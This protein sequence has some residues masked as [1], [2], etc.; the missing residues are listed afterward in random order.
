[1]V[2]CP[3]CSSEN[4][5]G[6]RFCS[7][8]GIS[9]EVGRSHEERKVI[10]ALFCDLVGSTA[11]GEQLDSEDVSRLLSAYRSICRRRIES[12][13]GVVEK[14]IGDA[15]VGVFGVPIAHEDDPERAVRAALKIV[16]D[17]NASDLDVEVRIGVNTGEA[18]VRLDVDPRL[19]EGFATGDALNT[20][21]RLESAAPTM[22]V[23]V[24]MQT[25]AASKTT[26]AYLDMPD[27]VAKGKA[28]PVSAWQALRPSPMQ[29]QKVRDESPFVGRELELTF[30][31]QLLDRSRSAPAT[32]FCTIIA[33]PGLGKSRL[34]RELAKH[35]DRLP[36][37]VT[38]RQGRCLPYGEGISF[39]ALGEIVKAEAGILESDD[40][41]TVSS[42]LDR[43]I[44]E[45]DPQTRSWVK[46]RL[47]P[48]VGWETAGG[49]PQRQEVFAAWRRFLEQ[50]A[51]SGPMVLVVEDLHWADPAFVAFLEEL[52]LRTVGLPLLVIVTAR[53]EVEEHHPSW[54]PGRHSTV[55]S[56]PP[57]SDNELQVLITETLPRPQS[58]LGRVILDRAGGSPLYAE[59][60]S[61][62]FRDRQA[63][64]DDEPLDETIIPSS[65]QALIAARI[66][67]LPP[68][69]KRA[70][71]NA[72]VVGRTFWAGAV[73][74]FDADA[75]L[76]ASFAELVRRD[77]CR[78]V[79]PS[80]MEGDQEFVFWHGLVRDVAYAELTRSE[81]S[82]MHAA[83]ALWLGRRTGNAMSE[84][85]EIVVHHID[86]AF[87]LAP[88]AAELDTDALQNLL[89]E[90]LIS[91]AQA[92]MRTEVPK[93]IEHL[94]RV[95]VIVPQGDPRRWDAL[96][97]LGHALHASGDLTRA[98]AILEELV[99][100]QQADG[101]DDAAAD[102]AIQLSGTMWMMGEG[103]QGDALVARVKERLGP[104]PTPALAKLLAYESMNLSLDH[105]DVPAI[106]LASKSLAMAANLRV[107]PPPR[108]LGARGMSRVSMGDLEGE[109]DIRQACDGFLQDLNPG[110]ASTMLFNL[111][112][113]MSVRGPR[114]ALPYYEE[115][116]EL[117]ERFGLEGEVWVGRAGRLES[118]AKMGRFDDVEREASPI[119]DWA[120]GHNDAFT[121][122]TV[123]SSLAVLDITRGGGCVD[124]SE[125]ADLARRMDNYD[126]LVRAAWLGL[127]AGATDMASGILDEVST[128]VLLMSAL[129][130]SRVAV[131][132]GRPEVAQSSLDRTTPYY[133]AQHAALFC[134]K[135][136]LAEADVDYLT[137]SNHYTE[138]VRILEEL[139]A[140]PDQAYSL[141]GLGRCLVGLGEAE[142]GVAYLTRSR[143]LWK[144][145]KATPRIA[146]IDSVLSAM[147]A[148]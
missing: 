135:A 71:M 136:I 2:V 83:T 92:S 27:V 30:L 118:L 139:G 112:D 89:A 66:D 62:M 64:T 94:E 43:A 7:S 23:V 82:R 15:V 12:H 86:A 130:L 74:E 53:P 132:L 93:A 96:R 21:A 32:E 81:R 31:K 33:E 147:T 9:L 105:D 51:A 80:T 40:Q 16:D 67:G 115:A 52:A 65:V 142:P 88:V 91:A 128:R 29:S 28:R 107:Q 100:H 122:F 87:N 146:E 90:A 20:A 11:L 24:G 10:T 116:T 111:A 113:V 79:H 121:R 144:G 126:G 97:L 13:G 120:V 85:A 1:M 39:W 143:E 76:D 141:A 106:E 110:G 45:E 5:D 4:G 60:L 127:E 68:G 55:L 103:E 73:F 41:E 129:L 36:E 72:S 145:L 95:L 44:V 6:S 84:N 63:P 26:I 117:P 49:T 134:A 38:W 99:A 75:E 48:L 125:L 104:T 46:A 77:L 140:V 101:D 137:A 18:L 57:L 114:V 61:A 102:A 19:G 109:R 42:K 124:P 133:P 56:L 50:I 131:R 69:P 54:P 148:D 22:G 119:L 8:C 70:L 47:A 37:T 138:A 58:G 17:V 123:M 3:A 34:V 108:A 35:V 59:Q 25:H 14:F 78:S 98:S